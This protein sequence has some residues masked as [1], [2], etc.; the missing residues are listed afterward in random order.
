MLCT[1]QQLVLTDIELK[2][3][4]VLSSSNGLYMEQHNRIIR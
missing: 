1:A 3:F 2:Y 4:Q